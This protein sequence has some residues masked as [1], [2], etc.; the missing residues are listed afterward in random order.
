[1]VQAYFENAA[2]AARATVKRALAEVP[3]ESLEPGDRPWDML[4]FV[5]YALHDGSA[6]R[7]YEASL[8]K[9]VP[10]SRNAT[11]VG[12]NESMRGLVALAENRPKDAI[13]LFE[14]AYKGD[15]GRESTGPVLAQAFD[16]TNQPDSAIAE[17]EKYTETVDGLLWTR[18]FFYAGSFK[19]LGELYDAKGNTAKALENYEKFVD[20]WKDADPELQPAVK[21]VRARI[22]D[23]KRKGGKG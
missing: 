22:E 8:E 2:A 11:T 18:R 14:T 19:Q 4:L 1:L 3:I 23:L 15:V 9:D 13:P 10:L 16:L 7:T 17:F 6:A 12:Y 5:A 21:T 20:L